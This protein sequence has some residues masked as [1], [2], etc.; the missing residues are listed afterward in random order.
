MERTEE[1]K[2]NHVQKRIHQ[3]SFAHILGRRELAPRVHM[4][5]GRNSRTMHVK[6]LCC[7]KIL[8][9]FQ[10]ENKWNRVKG[11]CVERKK[12]LIKSERKKK[13]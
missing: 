12:K 3:L 5:W 1:R 9:S 7:L 6:K 13:E 2:K 4:R 11:G 10:G 8:S